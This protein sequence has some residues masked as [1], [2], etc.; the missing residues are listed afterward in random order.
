MQLINSFSI[1]KRIEFIIARCQRYTWP[2]LAAS[3]LKLYTEQI[4]SGIA[5]SEGDD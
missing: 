5:L 3:P 2:V 4:D 1:K